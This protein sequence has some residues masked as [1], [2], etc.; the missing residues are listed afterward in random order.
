MK[1][2]ENIPYKE[3][4][5][6]LELFSLG[7]RRLRGDLIA[8][9]Q[10]LKGAYR[11]SKVGLFSWVAGQGE[12]ALSCARVSLGWISGNTS[13]QKGWLSTGIGSPGR[14]LSHHPW[15]CLKTVWMWR[16]GPWFSRG[17]LIKVVWL[18]CGWTRWSLRSL[19]T[20]AILRFCDSMNLVFKH[21][22]IGGDELGGNIESKPLPLQI[23]PED[24]NLH[25]I[26]AEI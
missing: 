16:S 9:F 7:K 17:L 1:G 25:V 21:R 2:L 4:L 22:M 15:M 13:L 26:T 12:K 6:E 5:K 10:Y 19:P 8:L 11:E 24:F 18:G 20:W 3:R 23:S 14:W